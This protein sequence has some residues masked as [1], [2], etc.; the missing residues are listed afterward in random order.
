MK[1][2]LTVLVVFSAAVA[3]GQCKKCFIGNCITATQGFH[4]C[5]SDGETCMLFGGVCPGTSSACQPVSALPV[6]EK[7]DFYDSQTLPKDLSNWS[8]PMAK[9]VRSLIHNP[10]VAGVTNGQIAD[11]E[12]H[13]FSEFT[14]RYSVFEGGILIL[15]KKEEPN[16]LTMQNHEWVLYREDIPVSSGNY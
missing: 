2:I 1:T 3:Y 13:A 10:D 14:F 9:I 15:D 12:G 11:Q 5:V 4:G 8:I 7:P 6:L 16:K